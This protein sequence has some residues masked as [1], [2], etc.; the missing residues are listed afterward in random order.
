MYWTQEERDLAKEL[1]KNMMYEEIAIKLEE[2]G[3]SRSAE[4][5]R[6]VLKKERLE[7]E[8]PTLNLDGMAKK[9]AD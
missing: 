2:Y 9:A 5:I 8:K 3:Y 4:G 1:R 6:C 7:K